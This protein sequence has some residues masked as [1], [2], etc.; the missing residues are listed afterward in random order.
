M[1]ALTGEERLTVYNGLEKKWMSG[2]I[3]K[4]ACCGTE[5]SDH[6]EFQ[7][8]CDEEM[9]KWYHDLLLGVPFKVEEV[10]EEGFREFC[11]WTPLSV[12]KAL[13]KAIVDVTL[14]DSLEMI[15]KKKDA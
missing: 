13:D 2:S 10:T 4:E 3:D 8:N 12:E 11:Q 15:S 6:C 9:Q 5:E 14:Y 1:N 7:S